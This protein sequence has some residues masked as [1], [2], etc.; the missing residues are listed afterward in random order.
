LERLV[1]EVALAGANA[2]PVVRWS[3]AEVRRYRGALYAMPPLPAIPNTEP[4][5]WRT[6]RALVLPSG[7]G[8]LAWGESGLAL[9]ADAIASGQL[10]VRFRGEGIAATPA[11]RE[12]RRSFKRIC[13]DWDIPPWLRQLVPLLYVDDRLAAIGD[14]LACEPFGART[15]R[16][17]VR[18]LWK[19]PLYLCQRA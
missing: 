1:S 17:A 18:L 16:R 2:M 9:D 7:L 5:D 14:L 13:Q 3:G 12:G 4:I 19:R 6:N 10:S 11:D 8:A 15:D